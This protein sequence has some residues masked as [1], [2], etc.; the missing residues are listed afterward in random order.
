MGAGGGI[1][2]IWEKMGRKEKKKVGEKV[3]EDRWCVFV[4]VCVYFEQL[5]A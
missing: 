3:G 2:E 1:E 4:C 5:H